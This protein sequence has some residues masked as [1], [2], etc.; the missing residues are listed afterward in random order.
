[1]QLRITL[2]LKSGS[3]SFYSKIHNLTRPRYNTHMCQNTIASIFGCILKVEG[4]S[5]LLKSPHSSDTELV[6]L[7]LYANLK[8][9]SLRFSFHSTKRCYASCQW[10]EEINCLS[11][12]WCL[13]TT[14]N[15][16][17]EKTSLK[18]QQWYPHLGRNH[19]F[20]IVLK[21]QSTGE[22]SCLLLET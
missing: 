19:S 7:E 8:A 3:S 16:Q 1:M 2:T 13:W 14:K 6:R 21:A 17:H 5:L 12:L 4:K 11:Q 18:V 10:R 15:D 20:L 9:L 22:K